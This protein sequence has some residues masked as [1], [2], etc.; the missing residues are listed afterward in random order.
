MTGRVDAGAAKRGARGTHQPW[1]LRRQSGTHN[2]RAQSKRARK[3]HECPTPTSARNHSRHDER[4][5]YRPK[6]PAS[7]VPGK[8]R[9]AP[10][11]EPL[12]QVSR[13]DGML[14]PRH[15]GTQD[16]SAGKEPKTG[17][18]GPEQG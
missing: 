2:E 13:P 5:R 11:R 12:G 17:S 1:A 6:A 9:S 10:V 7:D 15:E 18:D 16:A 8:D 3:Y 14:G 4:H